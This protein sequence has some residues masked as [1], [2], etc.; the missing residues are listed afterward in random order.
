MT[1]I[2][3]FLKNEIRSHDI[4]PWLIDVWQTLLERTDA[5]CA[6]S[7]LRHEGMTLQE[8]KSVAQEPALELFGTEGRLVL[9][10]KN[11]D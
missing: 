11:K 3:G 7:T 8:K 9:S 10:Q 2:G 1:S 4:V 5:R 6:N